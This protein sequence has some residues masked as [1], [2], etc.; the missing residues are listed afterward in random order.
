MSAPS[1]RSQSGEKQTGPY[2]DAEVAFIPGGFL[3]AVAFEFGKAPACDKSISAAG[4]GTQ[5]WAV[6]LVR[7]SAS[8]ARRRASSNTAFSA[9]DKRHQDCPITSNQ[10]HERGMDTAPTLFTPSENVRR[11]SP[12]SSRDIVAMCKALANLSIPR[13][14]TFRG[15]KAWRMK[16]V[17]G[18]SAAGFLHSHM[19]YAACYV[20]KG[21]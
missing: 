15:M 5:C 19:S 11:S 16:I 17:W 12:Q 6:S 9:S 21:K 13:Y 2:V 3:D 1:W 18:S 7:M 20:T 14:H 4:E 10:L 8:F